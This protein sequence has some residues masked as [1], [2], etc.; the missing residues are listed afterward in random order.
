M[1]ACRHARPWYASTDGR[2]ERRRKSAR[3]H[4]EW[5]RSKEDHPRAGALCIFFKNRRLQFR[6]SSSLTVSFDIDAE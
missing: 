3:P 5:V 4:V 1:A 6:D 2:H